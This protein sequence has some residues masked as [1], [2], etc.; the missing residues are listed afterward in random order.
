MAFLTHNYQNNQ[1][2]A[3][4]V[5]RIQ[6]GKRLTPRWCKSQWA[7]RG[8]G[9]DRKGRW[10]GKGKR[11]W[12]KGRVQGVP[13]LFERTVVGDWHSR[14]IKHW[15]LGTLKRESKGSK[16]GVK[17]EPTTHPIPT[18]YPHPVFLG[19]GANPWVSIPCYQLV[20]RRQRAKFWRAYCIP[21]TPSLAKPGM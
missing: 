15:T 2:M 3:I 12:Q 16:R 5:N 17:R 8:R 4:E 10:A 18:P 9:R 14:V 7:K 6:S 21:D 19:S 20:T 1:G 11:D 13:C